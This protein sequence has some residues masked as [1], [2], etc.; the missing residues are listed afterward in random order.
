MNLCL[1][2]NE[3]L[4]IVMSLPDNMK[5]L[6][7]P[8]LISLLPL[9][10]RVFLGGSRFNDD[11]I[12]SNDSYHTDNH[13]QETSTY[14]NINH[15]NSS[16]SIPFFNVPSSMILSDISDDDDD[17]RLNT[18]NSIPASVAIN[19]DDST[20]NSNYSTNIT[21]NNN[22]SFGELV[23]DIIT[24]RATMVLQRV[25]A[26][27][28]SRL[29]HILSGG[30]VHDSTLMSAFLVSISA[31]SYILSIN[32]SIKH[33]PSTSST[34]STSLLYHH[35]HHIQSLTCTLLSPV[36]TMTTL[37]AGSVICIR[38]RSHF[39]PVMK[40]CS[41]LYSLVGKYRTQGVVLIAIALV[42]SLAIRLKVH[43]RHLKWVYQIVLIKLLEALRN[44]EGY[45]QYMIE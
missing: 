36:L 31:L 26:S 28:T 16:H 24:S 23:N 9:N 6:K 8:G 15:N 11:I 1:N 19:N 34:S 43:V 10:W 17:Y 37:A 45:I 40:C 2:D 44:V 41:I 4:K 12:Q 14:F 7:Q 21:N 18:I 30:D 35:H 25:H 38:N 39:N 42:S 27:V 3:K 29:M 33:H 22:N 32:S 20:N 13:I 5:Y